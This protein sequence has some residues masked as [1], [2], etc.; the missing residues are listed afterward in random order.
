MR[1]QEIPANQISPLLVGPHLTT[2]VADNILKPGHGT[3]VSA[4]VIGTTVGLARNA[5]MVV[6]AF[7]QG[8]NL[9]E[10]WLDGLVKIYDDIVQKGRV[11]SAIVNLSVQITR[12]RTR[13]VNG[14]PSEGGLTDGVL[15]KMGKNF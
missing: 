2:T 12:V 15:D 8:D 9:S 1:V 10:S 14:N 5:N 6:T 11:N 4:K 13:D 7:K 3:C